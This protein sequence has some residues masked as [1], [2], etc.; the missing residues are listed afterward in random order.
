RL[1]HFDFPVFNNIYNQWEQP[2]GLWIF[3]TGQ[4]ELTLSAISL[5]PDTFHSLIVPGLWLALLVGVALFVGAQFQQPALPAAL[6]SWTIG[7][8]AAGVALALVAG[9]GLWSLRPVARAYP[10]KDLSNM[11]GSRVVDAATS[12]EVISTAGD[13][14]TPG[15]LAQTGPEMWPAGRYRWTLRL[16]ASGGPDRST[17]LATVTIRSP[18]QAVPGF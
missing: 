4:A 9:A 2:A 14:E 10:L 3:T 12:G 11:I 16:K 1:R 15:V 18:R 13:E 17:P 6:P 7:W 8:P 5:P